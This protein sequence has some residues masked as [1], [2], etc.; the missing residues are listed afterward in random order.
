MATV[1]T[2]IG[3]VKGNPGNNGKD[4]SENQIYSYNETVIGTWVNGKPIYR[5]AFNYTATTG[6]ITVA[7]LSSFNIDTI[8]NMYGNFKEGNIVEAIPFYLHSQ[9][10]VAP[11]YNL[12]DK[13]LK[14]TTNIANSSCTGVVIIEYTKTT[15]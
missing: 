3:N 12:K 14:V 5:K 9:Y 4:G 13:C 2:F 15:D 10:T 1:K 11:H 7:D 6:E 8:C